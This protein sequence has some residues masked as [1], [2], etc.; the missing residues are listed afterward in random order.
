MLLYALFE[1][2]TLR[3]IPHPLMIEVTCRPR[4]K[5][6]HGVDNLENSRHTRPEHSTWAVVT[7][8]EFGKRE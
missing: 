8:G 1:E 3:M 5:V 6:Q 7:L 4:V 2:V